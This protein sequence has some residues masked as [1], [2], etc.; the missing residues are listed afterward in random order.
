MI[1]ATRPEPTVRPPSRY[2]SNV[3]VRLFG[4]ISYDLNKKIHYLMWI[5]YG[6]KEFC[7]H[8]V[9]TLF[10]KRVLNEF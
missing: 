8:D 3:L 5:P 6:F 7:Y 2:W 10:I 9:I 1:V 4:V